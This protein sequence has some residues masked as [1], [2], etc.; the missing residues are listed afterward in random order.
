MLHLKNKD[1][2][3]YFDYDSATDAIWIKGHRVGVDLILDSYLA[4][5]NMV[6]LQEEF[7]SLTA[8]ELY[9]AITYY[10]LN[11]DELDRWLEQTHAEAA[12]HMADADAHPL[13]ATLRI[14]QMREEQRGDDAGQVPD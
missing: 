13:P 9:A 6:E 1:L 11:K 8:E 10:L 3:D 14:R 12:R 4:G 5:K 7:E 2:A